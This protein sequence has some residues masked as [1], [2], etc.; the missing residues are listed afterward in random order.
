[1]DAVELKSTDKSMILEV[2][3]VSPEGREMS[4]VGTEGLPDLMLLSPVNRKRS[5]FIGGTIICFVP[6]VTVKSFVLTTSL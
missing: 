4:G 1:M 2:R 6:L 3:N 5:L